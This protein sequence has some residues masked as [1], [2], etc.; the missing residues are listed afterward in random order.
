MARSGYW[1]FDRDSLL[2]ILTDD[3]A[4][5]FAVACMLISNA[6][7]APGKYPTPFGDLDLQPGDV[8][9]SQRKIAKAIGQPVA[10]VH[11][12]ITRFVA[13]G[14]VKHQLQ[15]VVRH[16]AKHLVKHLVKH[17]LT[18][19]TICDFDLYHRPVSESETPSETRSETRGET[20]SEI[21]RSNTKK[22]SKEKQP[23]KKQDG[24]RRD[25]APPMTRMQKDWEPKPETTAK[26]DA[27]YGDVVDLK[28]ALRKFKN[29]QLNKR[30][31]GGD[32]DLAFENWVI[33]DA[34]DAA[35]KT[36]G[37]G[38]RGAVP[39]SFAG[40]GPAGN[41]LGRFQPHRPTAKDFGQKTA[42]DVLGGAK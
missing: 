31:V 21:Y 36:A 13:R 28:L 39:V 26:L 20:R 10:T 40:P 12:W 11:R 4:V 1:L 16:D 15:H 7:I 33:G 29:H 6:A 41:K 38:N 9:L 19:L 23:I 8:V 22:Q 3:G 42:T 37:Q 32:W 35:T 17:G 2:R 24:G 34:Q 18:V 25:D 27:E 14:F 5:A 30:T